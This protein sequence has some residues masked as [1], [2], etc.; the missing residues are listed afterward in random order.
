[1]AFS[2]QRDVMQTLDVLK[3]WWLFREWYKTNKHLCILSFI[4]PIKNFQKPLSLPSFLKK[5]N[6]IPKFDEGCAW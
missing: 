3:D 5:K 4:F 1:M 2:V 6:Y